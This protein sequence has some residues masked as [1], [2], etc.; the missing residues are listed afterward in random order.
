MARGTL[1][2]RLIEEHLLGGTPEPGEVI[3]LRIDQTLIQDGGGPSILQELEVL[4]LDRVQV[5]VAAAYVDHNLLQTANH[6]PDDQAYMRTSARRLGIWFSPAGNGISH[7]VHLETFGT[8]GTT[9]LGADSHTVAGGAIGQLAIGAGGVD[10]A[11]AMAGTP[12]RLP[13]PRVLGVELTGALPPWTSAKDVI[14]EMLRRRGVTGG[15]GRIIEYFGPGLACLTVWDRHV[16]ANM[17]AELGAVASLFPAD[18]AVSQFLGAQGRAQD[19]TSLAA[20]LDAVYD[21]YEFLDLSAVEPLIACPYSPANVVPVAEVAGRP[22]AQAYIGSSAN[23]GYRDFA[24]AARIVAGQRAA[25][26]VALDVNPST[27]RVL[28]YLSDSGQLLSLIGAGARIHQ[29]GCNGCIG[30]GQAPATG[31]ISLRTTPRNFRGRTGTLDDHVYLA[32]PETVAVSALTGVITDPRTWADEPPPVDAPAAFREVGY[33][34]QAP[35]GPGEGADAVVVRGPNIKPLPRFDA[36]P[37]HL[38]LPVLLRLGDDESTEDIMPMQ[39]ENTV[40][41]SDTARFSEFV[42]SRT[43]PSYPARARKA[44]GGHAIVAGANYGQGSAREQAALCP[45]FLGLRIVV[46][47]SFA[48]I[49][50]RNLV[51]FGILPL[52]PVRQADLDALS[53]SDVLVFDGLRAAVT[54]A[55]DGQ[56]VT[57]TVAG[58]GQSLRL[59]HDLSAVQAD[60]VLAGGALEQARREPAE[61]SHR[62]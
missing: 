45:R 21:E 60:A 1:A 12:F 41:R 27:R 8:P 7:P 9:L 24:V 14:L 59:T 56:P 4:G 11:L 43:D 51:N 62:K 36:L 6:H 30:M 42:F 23:P 44:A 15:D 2:G 53:V 38:E 33:F 13:Y 57:C 49:Y 19:M 40:W 25:A 20:E 47:A 39:S 54:A 26:G 22:I 32:S 55:L 48:R 46:A 29:A 16:I 31:V 58:S 17:G 5:P 28:G 10:I 34:L 35:P 50:Q 3:A 52:R 18:D 37:D 61:A